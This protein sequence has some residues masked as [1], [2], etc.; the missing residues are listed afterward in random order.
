LATDLNN[1]L[2]IMNPDG[3]QRALFTAFHPTRAPLV[4]G[5]FV[6]FLHSTIQGDSQGLMRADA[7][8]S[9]VRKLVGEN[10]GSAA[11]SSDGKL[12]FYDTHD[13][14]QKI[15]RMPV[16]GGAPV[17]VAVIPGDRIERKFTLSADGTRLA[18]L[19]REFVDHAAAAEKLAVMP[20]DGGSPVKVFRMPDGV[21]TLRWSPD[22]KALQYK[23]CV[24]CAGSATNIW[25]QPL[26]GGEPSPSFRVIGAP[27]RARAGNIKPG[28]A[29][30]PIGNADWRS[31]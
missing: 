29:I 5:Q 2:W 22:G 4:C 12:V 11:C 9:N 21:H 27:G 7:D 1:Q 19:Y 16:E 20:T 14:P 15:R 31:Y 23:L 28:A 3:S 10:V 13:S 24:F 26:N 30:K 17:D 18:Y 8:G 25:E 6:I